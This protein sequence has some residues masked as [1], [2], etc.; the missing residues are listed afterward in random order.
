M[1]AVSVL[2]NWAPVLEKTP[3]IC[4]LYYYDVLLH[5]MQLLTG[6]LL[7]LGILIAILLIITII[8][9]N[10]QEKFFFYPT[11]LSPNY[12][13]EQFPAHKELF[14]DTPNNGRINALH[15]KRSNS[16]G[17][18]FYT[19][20]NSRALD[21]WAWVH[22]DFLP[23]NFD[24]LIYD[25]R[26]FGKSTG[27]INEQNLYGD[28][29]HIM[30]FLLNSY[31]T[32]QIVVYGRSLGASIATQ[33]ATEFDIAC[34]ILE[35]P[36]SSMLSIVHAAT[37]YIP[38]RYILRYKFNNRRKMRKLNCPVHILHG[39]KDELIPLRHAKRLRQANTNKNSTLTIIENASHNNLSEFQI[40]KDTIAQILNGLH[41]KSI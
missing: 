13:F 38:V 6:T 24:L 17:I 28:A 27:K 25:F 36:F 10:T 16:K 2:K 9:Y 34:L 14:F 41:S 39:T 29:R 12:P 30:Q 8:I 37:P 18:V 32:D 35:T 1:C 22:E 23:H 7:V 15:F 5:Q 3:I 33:M 31:K 20:G 11:K 19:H 40:Y 21:D 26:T 4:L